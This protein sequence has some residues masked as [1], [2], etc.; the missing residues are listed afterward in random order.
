MQKP[1]SSLLYV[2]V[3]ALALYAL[4]FL[5]LTA[6]GLLGPD[7]VRYAAI[8]RQMAR[9]GDWVTPT[10]WGEAWFEKPVL[11]YWMTAA[12][13]RCGLNEDLA[14][15]LP[16]AVLSVGFLCLFRWILA[17]ELGARAA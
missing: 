2:V 6:T 7:E 13:F 3:A 1:F 12:A 17:R 10:L 8:G 9:S 4:Y 16:V 11:L 15:R 5:G 14:P